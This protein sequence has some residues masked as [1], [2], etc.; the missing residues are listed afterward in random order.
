IITKRGTSE[1]PVF[2]LGVQTG[3]YGH[4]KEHFNFGAASD[5]MDYFFNFTHQQTDGY[6]DNNDYSAK[7]CFGRA[8][9]RPNDDLELELAAGY[10][11]DDYGM[12]GALYPNGNP[13]ALNPRGINQIGRTGTVFPED[14][15]WTEEFY[16]TVTPKFSI[17]LHSH[18]LAASIF[19]SFRSRRSKGLNIPEANAWAGRSEYETVH[20]IRSYDFKPKVEFETNLFDL[21]FE[22]RI[23]LGYDFFYALDEILSGDRL[24]QQDSVEITK[25]THGIYMHDNVRLRENILLNLGARAEWADFIFDQKRV[26]VNYETKDTLQGAC[27]VGLGYKYNDASQVY[28][29]FTKAYR[30]PN[31]EEYYQNKYFD[32]WNGVERGGLNQDLKAQKSNNFEIGI[33]DSSFKWLNL[34][35]DYYWMQTRS[36]IYFDP[37]AFSN[38]NYSPKT[39]RRGMELELTSSFFED[40]LRPY[41]NYIYQKAYFKGGK[42]ADGRIPL[43]PKQKISAGV[44]FP[45][46]DN[47]EWL[48][49]LNY[50]GSRFKVSDQN[51]IAPKLKPYTTVNT[52]L[53]YLKDNLRIYFALKNIFAEKYY[54]YGVTNSAGTAETFYPAPER[55]FEAGVNFSF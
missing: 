35:A 2:G 18:T 34:N 3:S 7:D 40:A 8:N 15:G 6:R 33:K 14:R 39:M 22:N 24:A 36:E 52:K 38:S 28:F 25:Q 47:L 17:E 21:G 32:A 54:S 46:S 42:Y 43:V 26:L 30:S 19:S 9:I 23:I 13:W 55:R 1:E 27:E 4:N 31:T 41:L 29:N 20:H 12:P 50:V 48:V 37:A 53:S 16:S 10:H 11:H 51:N 49:A 5:S 44:T 45:F